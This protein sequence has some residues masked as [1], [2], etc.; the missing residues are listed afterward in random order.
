M[1]S[2]DIT[3]SAKL[4]SLKETDGPIVNGAELDGN[5]ELIFS[6]GI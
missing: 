4:N 5:A 2:V 3:V 1:F 6:F